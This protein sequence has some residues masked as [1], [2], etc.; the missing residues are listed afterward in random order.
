MSSSRSN[1]RDR[2]PEAIL[3]EIAR[4]SSGLARAGQRPQ[5]TRVAA[6]TSTAT[7]GAAAAPSA[8]H[9]D[10]AFDLPV[11]P[12]FAEVDDT[13]A[14]R[15]S[16]SA[17]ASPPQFS[18][19]SSSTGHA[20][21]A[22]QFAQPQP[23][24]AQRLS[25]LA[26]APILDSDSDSDGSDD[27]DVPPPPGPPPS[28]TTTTSAVHNSTKSATAASS[29]VSPPQPPPPPPPRDDSDDS[30]DSDQRQQRARFSAAASEEGEEGE[31]GVTDYS[32][33]RDPDAHHL[34]NSNTRHHAAASPEDKQPPRA[35]VEC[36]FH[37]LRLEQRVA[38]ELAGVARGA[39]SHAAALRSAMD[40]QRELK[41]QRDVLMHRESLL[42]SRE[43]ET[44]Y[45]LDEVATQSRGSRNSRPG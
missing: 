36:S 2:D 39:S 32:I 41:R 33:L 44:A 7:N 40:R 42:A 5:P 16:A 17:T 27:S 21:G 1:S 45:Q 6:S 26:M 43:G 9:I 31:E 15:A 25:K 4:L 37:Q 22:G 30:D 13:A 18:S 3:R 34:R 8:R 35:D 38:G 11:P 12:V 20:T 10:A 14:G 24:A 28:A 23:T 29:S 19:T